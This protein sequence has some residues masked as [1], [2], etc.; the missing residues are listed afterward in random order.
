MTPWP[1]RYRVRT[2]HG[3]TYLVE[4]TDIEVRG[5]MLVLTNTTRSCPALILYASHVRSVETD[6]DDTWF[7]LHPRMF[8]PHPVVTEEGFH[9]SR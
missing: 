6:A 1:R 3:S 8:R 2:V 5:G 7:E 9:G 4:A